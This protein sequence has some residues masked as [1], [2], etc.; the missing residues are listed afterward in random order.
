MSSLAI[1]TM[2]TT[3]TPR[4][5]SWLDV[6]VAAAR[7]ELSPQSIRTLC[8][9]RWQAAGLAKLERSLG[10][11]KARWMIR[12]DADER[13]ARIKF[14][15]KI[16]AD[17]RH[18]TAARRTLLDQRLAVYQGWI[19]RLREGVRE[20]Q[21]VH[22]AT[23]DY[24]AS[25]AD[26]RIDILDETTLYRWHRR[27]RAKGLAGLI[28]Q[29]WV[30]TDKVDAGDPF[31]AEALRHYLGTN[32]IKVRVCW[33][34]ACAE[35]A[36]QGW[37]VWSYAST[38]RHLRGKINPGDRILYRL[39]ETAFTNDAVAYIEGDYSTLAS[40]EQWESDHH[41]HDVIVQRSGR[42]D[43]GTGEFKPRYFR[44]WGTYWMDR[45][46]R[47]IVGFVVYD[48]DPDTGRILLALRRGVKANGVP[49]SA[50]V[51]NGKDYASY[52]LHGRTKK[53]RRAGALFTTCR[54]STARSPAWTSKPTTSKSFTANRKTS[55][56]FSAPW[57]IASDARFR[58]IAQQA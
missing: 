17:L 12:E 2:Q 57:R 52:A 39:G 58:R 34:L 16:P 33:E 6:P 24:L 43:T 26:Q 38:A 4:A 40:N 46:S 8:M 5:L 10:G 51:D 50:W 56:D 19:A 31:I 42:T 32:R 9:G 29:R 49:E 1:P 14:P 21:T 27:Y 48:G 44:P 20:G 11:G 13:L 47:K 15:D 3:A 18:L 55:N 54:G 36:K 37:R 28:D 23:M 45:R 7:M 53:Q 35:A 41:L 30:K 22:A 25:G